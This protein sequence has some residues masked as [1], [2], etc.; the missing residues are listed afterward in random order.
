MPFEGMFDDINPN[1]HSSTD[2]VSVSGFNW[3][4]SL[5]YAK[6]ATAYAYELATV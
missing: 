4:H 1:I 2:T 3:T 5:Q 6:F